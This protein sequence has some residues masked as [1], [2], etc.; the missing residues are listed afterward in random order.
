VPLP[1]HAV[2]TTR[3]GGRS[4]AGFA[5]LNLSPR[6]GDRP[7]RVTENRDA[8]AR[9]MHEL[10]SVTTPG[11]RAQLLSPPQEH[12]LRVMSASEW[13]ATGPDTPCDGLTIRLSRDKGLAPVLL[14]ADCVP[15]ILVGSGEMAVLHCGWR[16]LLGGMVQAGAEALSTPPRLAFVGPSIGPCCFPVQEDVARAF[17][18]R[19]G[20]G[21]LGENGGLDLWEVAA[22]ALAETGIPA[23]DV[24]NPRLCTTCNEPFFYS[25]RGQNGVA[26]RQGAAAWEES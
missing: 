1:F 6:V 19:Y 7:E 4:V 26:G 17:A 3:L 2:F 25:H 20:P 10:G 9:V 23:A 14:F 5:S 21:L 15:I 18:E 24:V 11:T 22:R 13:R 16:G 8:L 12:G